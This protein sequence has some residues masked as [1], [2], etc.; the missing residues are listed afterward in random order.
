M[1]L[2]DGS[3]KKSQKTSPHISRFSAMIPT[4]NTLN[5]SNHA[6]KRQQQRNIPPIIVKWLFD[7]GTSIRHQGAEVLYFDHQSIRNLKKYTG[8]AFY[9][10]IREFTNSYA[11]VSD[12]GTIITLGRKFKHF[13]K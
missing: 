6:L 10:K 8:K 5:Y 13:R 11:V 4:L 2:G 1:E 7:F 3:E 9:N 12:D